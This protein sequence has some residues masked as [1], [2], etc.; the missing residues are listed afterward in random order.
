MQSLID[1]SALGS[2][3]R[4]LSITCLD[5]GARRGFTDDVRLIASAVNAVGFEPDTD[6]CERLNAEANLGSHPWKKLH[7]LP[8]ALAAT[9][10]TS[11]LN[12]YSQPGCSSLLEADRDLAALYSRQDYYGL[13]GTVDVPALPLDAAAEKFCFSDASYLK[14]DIQ[15]GELDVFSGG[16][17]L[18]GNS[19]LAI[20][21]EVSFMPMYKDQP[22]FADIDAELRRH[23]F[24]PMEFM[25]LHHWRRTSKT[26]P[27]RLAKGDFPYSHGQMIHGD[28]LYFRHPETMPDDNEIAIEKLLKAAFLAIAYHHIDHASAIF[29]RQEISRH[30]RQRYGFSAMDSLSE[31]ST[32]FARRRYRQ[33]ALRIGRA[34]KNSIHRIF[35]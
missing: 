26:K 30:V 12:L 2:V 6:E 31:L 21:T 5:V 29:S 27:P 23:G 20:R 14:I 16:Q 33:G 11:R 25:E 15:G 35:G 3:L 18:L 7:F 9:E 13:T 8:V 34:A 19:L 32:G 28:V 10:G 24:V 22:L 4:D 1:K 17:R